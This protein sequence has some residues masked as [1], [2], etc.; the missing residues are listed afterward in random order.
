MSLEA[1]SEIMLDYDL[2]QLAK[3]TCVEAFK[4]N[5]IEDL[6]RGEI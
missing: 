5:N 3:L 2:K 1:G 4:F 6:D